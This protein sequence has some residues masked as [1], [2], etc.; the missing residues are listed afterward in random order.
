MSMSM[1]IV[2]APLSIILESLD[3]SSRQLGQLQESKQ[4][5][6]RAGRPNDSDTTKHMQHGTARRAALTTST[7]ALPR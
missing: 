6:F 3:L 4:N 1:A 5:R 7:D 2:P